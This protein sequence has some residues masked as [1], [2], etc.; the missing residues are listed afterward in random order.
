MRRLPWRAE[1]WR[2][3]CESRWMFGSSKLF[4]SF[5]PALTASAVAPT[6]ASRSDRSLKLWFARSWPWC[7]E[8]MVANAWSS[9]CF[10]SSPW[11]PC[12]SNL[13]CALFRCCATSSSFPCTCLTWAWAFF[14]LSP[15]SPTLLLVF[16]W[17]SCSFNVA[18][19]KSSRFIL[20]DLRPPV[21]SATRFS[22][23]FINV[24]MSFWRLT[25][26]F[27]LLLA[28]RSPSFCSFCP[29]FSAPASACSCWT[30]RS[31]RL[32]SSR[33]AF[34]SRSSRFSMAS[35]S[36]C[37]L[38]AWSARSP[39]NFLRVVSVTFWASNNPATL[40]FVPDSPA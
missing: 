12:I 14:A 6:C 3:S 18:V 10:K 20:V 35:L 27:I 9:F 34:I 39:S 38:S 11:L 19:F 26:S 29:F 28:K 17:S 33:N 15:R 4:D 40:S 13:I 32:K 31:V 22:I 7:A 8:A 5:K 23:I 37:A 30:S 1:A 16:S 24:S 21:L 25:P 2:A 36:W